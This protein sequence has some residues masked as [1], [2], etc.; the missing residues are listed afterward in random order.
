MSD[1]PVAFITGAGQGIGRG[2]AIKLAETGFNIAANDIYFNPENTEKGLFEVKKII[3]KLN[4]S[5]LPVNGDIADI[6]EHKY[7]LN[8]VLEK[9]G[10]IDIL[11]N[12]A[13]VA[14]EKR[15]DILETT[16]ESYDRVLGINSRGPFFF[17]Q[18]VSKQMIEQ[19]RTKSEFKPK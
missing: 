18:V 9:Y 11:V 10:K 2:I 13:G 19:V 4:V 5:F 7:I 1:K 16:P 17:T 12:N 15:M 8:P 6:N 3:E 14:P